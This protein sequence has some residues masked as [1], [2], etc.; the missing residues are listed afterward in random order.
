MY[1]S[2]AHYD[3]DK[4][5]KHEKFNAHYQDRNP[6][7]K[8]TICMTCT[9]QQRFTRATSLFSCSVL[10]GVGPHLAV[11]TNN[12]TRSSWFLST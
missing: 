8:C 2:P 1:K 3:A 9:G 4:H 5:I 12:R 7:M 10:G 11:L 6:V